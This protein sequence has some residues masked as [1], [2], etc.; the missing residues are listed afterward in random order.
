[1]EAK[2]EAGIWSYEKLQDQCR[3]NIYPPNGTCALFQVGTDGVRSPE[4][5]RRLV[6]KIILACNAS[7]ELVAERND[8][9][10]A[11]R[12]IALNDPFNQS[13]AG[14]IARAALAKLAP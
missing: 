10:K 5:V 14:I 12:E 9:V 4:E 1:M 2:Q 7:Q 8:L 6:E 3:Y 11:L 13:S